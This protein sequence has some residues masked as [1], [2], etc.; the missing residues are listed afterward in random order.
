[1]QTL[2]VWIVMLTK[3]WPT[4]LVFEIIQYSRHSFSIINPFISGKHTYFKNN[5]TH[6]SCWFPKFNFAIKW[7]NTRLLRISMSCFESGQRP[8]EI[9]IQ[10]KSQRSH[11]QRWW[12]NKF[13][14]LLLLHPNQTGYLARHVVLSMVW[15]SILVIRH[16]VPACGHFSAVPNSNTSGRKRALLFVVCW[17]VGVIIVGLPCQLRGNGI[18]S[19]ITFAVKREGKHFTQAGQA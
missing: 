3:L 10:P 7:S 12:A 11:G 16:S 18:S 2:G 4:K 9:T 6:V 13:T 15:N 8:S 14:P 1:M 5:C 17:S 19:I